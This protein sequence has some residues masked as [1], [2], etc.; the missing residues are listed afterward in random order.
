VGRKRTPLTPAQEAE[1]TA[2]TA[3]GESAATIKAAVP[4][5]PS[6]ATIARRQEELRGAAS[7]EGRV[8]PPAVPRGRRRRRRAGQPPTSAPRGAGRSPVLPGDGQAAGARDEIPGDQTDV[9]DDVPDGTPPE[10]LDAWIVRLERAATLAE[11]H[12]NLPALASIAAKVTA[13]MSLKHRTAPLPKPDQ[14]ERPDY[15]E[16]AR[17]GEERLL[18]LIRG[19]FEAN[20]VAGP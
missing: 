11:S 7:P 6:R 19:T 3:R 9:P 20:G 15:L 2:R 1:I 18:K 16:L 13:L 10:T 4:A 14:N 17:V 8:A 5:M 12:G